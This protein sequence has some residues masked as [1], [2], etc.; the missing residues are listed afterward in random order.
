MNNYV[1][2]TIL[3]AQQVQVGPQIIYPTLLHQPNTNPYYFSSYEQTLNGVILNTNITGNTGYL[4]LPSP[5]TLCNE[6]NLTGFNANVSYEMTIYYPGA[7]I[8]SPNFIIQYTGLTGSNI[9]LGPYYAQHVI[10][11]LNPEGYN[12]GPTGS[13]ASC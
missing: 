11:T 9:T 10:L 8:G 2:Q 13:L 12:N 5:T 6:M 1:Y 3:P 7:I 4:Y